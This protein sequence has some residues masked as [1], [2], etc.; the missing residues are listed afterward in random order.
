MQYVNDAIKMN[1]F[2]FA[3]W[4]VTAANLLMLL[5]L[6][7]KSMPWVCKQTL[8]HYLASSGPLKL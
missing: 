5:Q 8:V 1:V 7:F 2:N 3:V 4:C 6:V